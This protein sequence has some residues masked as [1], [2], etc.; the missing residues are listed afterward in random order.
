V[1]W[2]FIGDGP[3]RAWLE[4]RMPSSACQTVH[5]AGQ[6]PQDEVS[7]RCRRAD[8]VVLVSDYEGLTIGVLEGMAE[9]LVPVVTTQHGECPDMIDPTC[10]CCVPPDNPAA[11]VDV[12]AQLA[13]D[14]G[15]REGMQRAAYD[16]ICRE[17]HFDRNIAA[18]ES[19]I[20]EHAPSAE[21]LWPAW[22]RFLGPQGSPPDFPTRRLYYS[23][24][25]RPARRLAHMIHVGM[26]RP[27]FFSMVRPPG[28]HAGQRRNPSHE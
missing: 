14:S 25:L 28:S 22:R 3:A 18:W 7:R 20:R 4:S 12:L 16:K 17:L 9:G 1:D 6:V 5:F 13:A 15:W 19:L 2:T 8:V 24:P 11:F 10:G 21:P 27:L 23:A 26:V